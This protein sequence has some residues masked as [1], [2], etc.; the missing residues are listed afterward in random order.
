MNISIPYGS[1]KYVAEV[2]DDPT[3]LSITEP[4]VSITPDLFFQT[5]VQEIRQ[6]SLDLTDTIIVVTD[7]TRVCGYGTYLPVLVDALKKCGLADD[8]LQFIIAYGTH[9]RQSD[10]ECIA[11]YGEI[12]NQYPFIHHNC[13]DLTLFRDCGTTSRGVPIRLRSDLLQATSLI[14]MGPLCHHYFAGY[15][16]GRKLIFPGCG[17]REAIYANHCLYLDRESG[18]LAANCQPGVMEDNPLAEDLFEVSEKKQADLAIHGIMNSQGVLCDVIAGSGRDN[19]LEACRRHGTLCESASPSFPVVVASCGGFP[20]DINFIQS[21][22]AIHNAAMFVD[23]GGTLL[24]FSECRDGIGSETFLPWFEMGGFTAAFNHLSKK[25]QGNGGTALA[26]MTKTRRIR[27]AMITELSEN[28]C[29]TIGVEKWSFSEAADY[30]AKLKLQ[31]GYIANA[32][33]LVR[34]TRP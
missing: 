6:R 34:K 2:S 13:T 28:I 20:K 7:K 8:G 21:H 17:E 19:F 24:M 29:S 31:A 14:T 22:K 25:Y 26:M 5:V 27:I 3:L 18:Q 11:C 32:S 33:L 1:K 30:M 12:Y 23:D 9:P 4:E 15:G 16:G 10:G